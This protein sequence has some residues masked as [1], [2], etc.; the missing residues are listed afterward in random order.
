MASKDTFVVSA[1]TPS[2]RGPI[3]DTAV[4]VLWRG[5]RWESHFA[6]AVNV[7]DRMRL[8]D[9]WE[10]VL[11]V[12]EV[13]HLPEKRQV[14]FTVRPE[15]NEQQGGVKSAA[16]KFSKPTVDQLADRFDYH[17]PTGDQPK[18]YEEVRH[19]I[20]QAAITCV[21]LTPCCPEQ[22]RALNALDEAMFLFNAAIA[23]N[24]AE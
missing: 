1:A 19:A 10:Q 2:R 18:R 6:R 22:A 17:K 14:Y 5:G 15:E 8:S 9:R 13:S 23:R 4:V 21:G 11:T 20:K 24:P 16:P 3:T 7:G 12:L